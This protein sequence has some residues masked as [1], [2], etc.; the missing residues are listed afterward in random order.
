MSLK[1]AVEDTAF[2]FKR[3]LEEH[4]ILRHPVCLGHLSSDLNPIEHA[5]DILKGI[6]DLCSQ[7]VFVYCSDSVPYNTSPGDS[8]FL[9]LPADSQETREHIIPVKIIFKPCFT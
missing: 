4:A 3:W 6:S 2:T 1:K 9:E 5:W 8:I 7:S